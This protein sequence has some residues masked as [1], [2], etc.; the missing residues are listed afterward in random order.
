MYL[1][2]TR[3]RMGPPGIA[4]KGHHDHGGG[5]PRPGSCPRLV[6]AGAALENVHLLRR[7]RREDGTERMFLLGEDVESSNVKFEISAM[8][9]W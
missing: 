8:S 2:A 1:G 7:V 3:G 6:A 5:L 9:A 4:G